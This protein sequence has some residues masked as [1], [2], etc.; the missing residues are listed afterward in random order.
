[1]VLL[2]NVKEGGGDPV[3]NQVR[4]IMFWLGGIPSKVD[5]IPNR[6]GGIQPAY[7]GITTRSAF[8]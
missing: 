5:G 1:M 3:V 6:F 8:G 2:K 7:G 4:G